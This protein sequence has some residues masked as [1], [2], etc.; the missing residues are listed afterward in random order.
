[1]AAYGLGYA[2]IVGKRPRITVAGEG[3]TYEE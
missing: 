2:A 1:M 3:S